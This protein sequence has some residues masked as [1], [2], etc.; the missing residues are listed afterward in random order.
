MFKRE[1]Y[2]GDTLQG[3]LASVSC[4]TPC[5]GDNSQ[6]C[7][8]GNLITV[9]EDLTWSNPTRE[10]LAEAL[11]ALIYAMSDLSRALTD[12]HDV[13]VAVSSPGRKMHKRAP[14][15]AAALNRARSSASAVCA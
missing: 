11:I 13:A 7:G 10:E 15:L 14:P 6:I 5:A 1:C 9:Y 8:G 4:D 12:W 3:T 2:Y